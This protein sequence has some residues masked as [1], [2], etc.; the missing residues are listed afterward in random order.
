[1]LEVSTIRTIH[2]YHKQPSSSPLFLS[3]L[4]YIGNIVVDHH[5]ILEHKY[6]NLGNVIII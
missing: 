4:P 3:L 2:T 5:T 1:M 6:D